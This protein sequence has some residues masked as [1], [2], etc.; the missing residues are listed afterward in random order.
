MSSEENLVVMDV[1]E[2]PIERPNKG[3][4]R[5]WFFSTCYAKLLKYRYKAM[6]KNV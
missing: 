2:S 3:Q 1:T 6:S 5:F 4:K